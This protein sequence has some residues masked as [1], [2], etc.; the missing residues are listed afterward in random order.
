MSKYTY[1]HIDAY[2][3]NFARFYGIFVCFYELNDWNQTLFI[4]FLPLAS[5]SATEDLLG[6]FSEWSLQ[7]QSVSCVYLRRPLVSS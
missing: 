7:W 3:I 2:L 5:K 4:S 1:V 6:M